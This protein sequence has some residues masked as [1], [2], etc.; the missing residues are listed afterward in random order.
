PA[1]EPETP[2]PASPI[3]IP[4]TAD[5]RLAALNGVFGPAQ[6]VVPEAPPQPDTIREWSRP[7]PSSAAEWSS[8]AAT[9]AAE[10]KRPGLFGFLKREEPAHGAAASGTATAPSAGRAGPLA[11]LAD[12]LLGEYNGGKDGTGRLDVGNENV[13]L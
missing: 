7:A 10:V 9:P 8:S 2:P 6:P 5:E 1:V 13:D 12:A 11:S 3:D 4:P